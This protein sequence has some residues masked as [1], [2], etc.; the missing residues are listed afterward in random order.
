MK[1]LFPTLA[2]AAVVSAGLAMPAMAQMETDDTTSDD[3]DASFQL[4]RLRDAG[5]DA[6]AVADAGDNLLRVTVRLDDGGQ[7]FVYYDEDTLEPD[8]ATGSIL[9]NRPEPRI[10]MSLESLTHDSSNVDN[11]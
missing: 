8:E 4:Q 1:K 2:L 5:V 9:P 6:L 11:E 10:P 7:A 3:F